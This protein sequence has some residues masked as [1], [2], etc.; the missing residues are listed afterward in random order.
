M[1]KVIYDRTEKDI[2][3][4]ELYSL[5][6]TVFREQVKKSLKRLVDALEQGKYCVVREMHVNGNSRYRTNKLF[7]VGD[8]GIVAIPGKKRTSL[9]IDVKT[10]IN[11]SSKARE[12]LVLEEGLERKF[13][14]NLPQVFISANGISYMKF[15][16]EGTFSPAGGTWISHPIGNYID[17]III[18]QKRIHKDFSQHLE[19][20]ELRKKSIPF[21][22]P[23][24]Y[25]TQLFR[26]LKFGNLCEIASL[27][28]LR[29]FTEQGYLNDL[30]DP[31]GKLNCP[32]EFNTPQYKRFWTM[33]NKQVKEFEAL[34]KQ[35]KHL[36]KL[37]KSEIAYG[38]VKNRVLNAFE[39]SLRGNFDICR[40]KEGFKVVEINHPYERDN[41][42]ELQK[43]P[44]RKFK[45]VPSKL[46]PKQIYTIPNDKRSATYLFETL[47][48][49]N[50]NYPDTIH[51]PEARENYFPASNIN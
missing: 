40:D 21:I 20:F 47:S 46:I 37:L 32:Y 22:L 19:E 10:Q 3:L 41:E 33:H 30:K 26:G 24:Q 35:R 11:P 5:K 29:V 42:G 48:R 43:M 31:R 12:K 23:S 8:Q 13:L 17:S 34:R 36:F 39:E 1:T 50:D 49:F 14:S 25:I 15:Y 27:E 16:H 28:A 51:I 45:I 9:G 6:G 4:S 38:M 18:G 44:K 2:D 7:Q